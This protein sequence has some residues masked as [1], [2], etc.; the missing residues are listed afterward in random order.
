MLKRHA[1]WLTANRWRSQ[2][3]CTH[4]IHD[5]RGIRESC[6]G[7]SVREAYGRC[8]FSFLQ[9]CWRS[10]SSICCFLTGGERKGT[11]LGVRACSQVCGW[12]WTSHCPLGFRSFTCKKTGWTG[13]SEPPSSMKVSHSES[14]R[15]CPSNW[16]DGAWGDETRNRPRALFTH[17]ALA[18][19]GLLGPS[20]LVPHLPHPAQSCHCNSSGLDG[21]YTFGKLMYTLELFKCKHDGPKFSVTKK[22]F[23]KVLCNS[24]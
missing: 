22:K 20:R 17:W 9:T 3:S 2:P 11:E 14:Q 24:L 6:P 21:E 13:C 4:G 18:A 12:Y 19:G 5:L 15:S 7:R 8:W 23:T 1:Y 16:C 10:I